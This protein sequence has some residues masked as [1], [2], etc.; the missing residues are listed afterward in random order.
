MRP[1]AQ[2]F[3]FVD[4]LGDERVREG[5]LRRHALVRFPLDTFLKFHSKHKV[6]TK[7]NGALLT[8]VYE[9]NEVD[10]LSVDHLAK[11]LGTWNA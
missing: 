4:G 10:I 8:Y 6:L 2:T 7:N 1:G 9:I 11:V 5:H 3:E